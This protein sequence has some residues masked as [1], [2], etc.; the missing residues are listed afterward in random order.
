LYGKTGKIILKFDIKVCKGQW[1][2]NNNFFFNY[3]FKSCKSKPIQ[4]Y[5]IFNSI[6]L[7]TE[8]HAVGNR[9]ITYIIKINIVCYMIWDGIEML[10]YKINQ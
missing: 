4:E 3:S 1:N 5:I 10:Q 8:K 2:N 7:R 6:W 9:T